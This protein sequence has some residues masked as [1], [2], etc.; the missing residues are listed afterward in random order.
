MRRI[1]KVTM[2]TE[3]PF[4]N[5]Y[6]LDAKKLNGELFKYYFASRGRG[7]NL[8]IHTKENYPEG[9]VIYG[10]CGEKHDHIVLVRQ[11]RFPINDYIYELPAGLVDKGE[12]YE[13]TGIREFK[14]ETGMSLELYQGGNKAYRRPFYTTVGLTDESITIVYGYAK[15]N[16]STDL[17]E[18]T[19]D[20]QVVLA[21][22]KEA[23]R[24]LK[25]EKVAMKCALLLMQFLQS[26]EESPFQFLED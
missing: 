7:E 15:G 8:K 5:L 11:F 2:L 14:E 19:E 13:E 21:D 10:V 4:V 24:I 12:T 22:K 1:E 18:D 17:M 9:V 26:T 23:K 16:P 6:E 20:I 3:N 25:E